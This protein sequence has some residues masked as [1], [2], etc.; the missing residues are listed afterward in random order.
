MEKEINKK[1]SVSKNGTTKKVG[2]KKTSTA[3]KTSNSKNTSKTT[4]TNTTTKKTTTNTKKAAVKKN[5]STVKN[6]DKSVVNDTKSINPIVEEKVVETNKEIIKEKKIS[7]FKNA[8]SN[9]T[10]FNKYIK[11]ILGLTTL[12]L[13]LYFITYFVV[14]KDGKK[15]EEDNKITASIQYEEII[16]SKMLEQN[17]NEYIVLIYDKDDKF[18]ATYNTYLS[19]FKYEEKNKAYTI[20]LDSD[21][22]KYLKGEKNN[23]IV[24]DYKDFKTTGTT[25]IK[26][27]NKKIIK[28][29]QGKNDIITYLK[30][31]SK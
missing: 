22:N 29:Y 16:A 15:E 20:N 23:H 30:E 24:S 4:K 11:I 9:D 12:I 27:S 7:N 21:F 25:L 10:D 2:T 17:G 1:K 19:T 8:L 18:L 28:A 6:N 14:N 13:L 3:K 26:V 5:N 31:I